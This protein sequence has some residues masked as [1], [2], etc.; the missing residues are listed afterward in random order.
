MGHKSKI[1]QGEIHP[2]H[3]HIHVVLDGRFLSFITWSLPPASFL[4]ATSTHT[5]GHSVSGISVSSHS[6]SSAAGT[7]PTWLLSLMNSS[8]V[9]CKSIQ[10]LL[11]IF[12][13]K[14]AIGLSYILK[15]VFEPR[16]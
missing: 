14:E 12:T 10:V 5:I 2:P 7:V 11:Y 9:L 1:P 13:E 15:G 6:Q 8:L 4:T 3:T 16:G